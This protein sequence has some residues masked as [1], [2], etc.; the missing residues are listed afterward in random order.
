MFSGEDGF[1]FLFLQALQYLINLYLVAYVQMG[2][3]LVEKKKRSVL[4]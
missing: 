4:G 2:T 3:G 1:A